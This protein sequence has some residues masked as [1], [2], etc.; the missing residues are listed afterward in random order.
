MDTPEKANFLETIRELRKEADEKLTGNR[1]Y[2]A[3]Q[4]LDEIAEAVQQRD[5]SSEE[6]SAVSEVLR[7]DVGEA[8][9]TVVNEPASADEQIDVVVPAVGIAGAAGAA[10]AVDAVTTDTPNAEALD[11]QNI[12]SD[13]EQS[14]PNWWKD[15]EGGGADDELETAEPVIEPEIEIV[16]EGAP[17]SVV[18]NAE[19][20]ALDLTSVV[21]GAAVSG[22]AAAVVA[23]QLSSETVETGEIAEEI[24]LIEVPE[25]EIEAG[26]V[27]LPAINVEAIEPQIDVLEEEI[28]DVAVEAAPVIEVPDI[29]AIAVPE[30]EPE[31]EIA[32]VPEATEIE[33]IP[34]IAAD[35]VEVGIEDVPEAV[36][37]VVP[38]AIVMPEIEI[39]AIPDIPVADESAQIAGLL[40]D[41]DVDTQAVVAAGAA[42]AAVGAAG[43][44]LHDDEP[45]VP[46][47]SEQVEIQPEQPAG[48]PAATI[49]NGENISRHPT[50]GG[51]RGGI[52]KRFVN[53]L[54]GKDFI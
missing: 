18:E 54:R 37:E 50:Y 39:A 6:L 29:E 33:V 40:S 47:V 15:K 20:S 16:S 21:T 36:I 42:A 12:T 51:N 9:A 10:L 28:A 8:P 31:V 25:V 11:P 45:S 46:E 2:L 43:I 48:V 35:P 24:E 7:G 44:A 13:D 4:K 14:I 3:I 38:E 52:L 41:V 34:E 22:V 5:M 19:E 23:G 1:H 49:L 26:D 27:A 53:A 32:E 17:E 30:I